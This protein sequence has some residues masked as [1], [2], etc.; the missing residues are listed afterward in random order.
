LLK[1]TK[2]NSTQAGEGEVSYKKIS[3]YFF[4]EMTRQK[5]KRVLPRW[6]FLL[7]RCHVLVN[8]LR[9]KVAVVT[10]AFNQIFLYEY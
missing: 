7:P 6:H 3:Y 1:R 10:N 4:S 9:Y 8:I 5:E 2:R